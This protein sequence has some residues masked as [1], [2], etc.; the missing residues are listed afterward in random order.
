MFGLNLSLTTRKII[1]MVVVLV[2]QETSISLTNQAVI[3]PFRQSLCD[4][5]VQGRGVIACNDKLI[6]SKMFLKPFVGGVL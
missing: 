2:L 3:V 6:A 5:F 4:Y 1:G